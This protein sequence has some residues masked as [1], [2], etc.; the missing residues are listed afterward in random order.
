MPINIRQALCFDD[1]QLI[2]GFNPVRSRSEVSL[3]NDEGYIPIFIA[4]MMAVNSPA[5]QRAAIEA[6]IVH[7][8]HRYNT[9]Q[10]RLDF[11][12][13]LELKGEGRKN[14]G[15]SIGMQDD[16]YDDI[17]RLSEA[18]G[19][20][21]FDVAACYSEAVVTHLQKILTYLVGTDTHLIVGNYSNPAFAELIASL[22]PK[23]LRLTLKVSQGG[24]GVCSTRLMTG[25]GVP[26]F[27]AVVDSA[28]ITQANG[29]GLIADGG[30]KTPGDM[31]KAFAAGATGV[32][33]GGMFAAHTECDSAYRIVTEQGVFYEYFG[34][35]SERAKK[36]HFQTVKNVEGV[37]SL[38]RHKGHV[39]GTI[40]TIKDGLQSGV[41]M[42]GFSSLRDLIGEGQFVQV[43]G[44]GV[45]EAST[46]SK[47]GPSFG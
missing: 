11:V 1:V 22:A 8:L 3:E 38:K 4:P 28:P 29:Y 14:I 15:L 34:M 13:G 16:K 44:A 6:N 33:C 32:M 5:M 42:Q 39:K 43:S 24:S 46:Y 2:D 12:S 35:A 20:L 25:V 47:I 7:V 21:N 41:S 36:Q 19:H 26:T 40:G 18:A 45:R 10:D 30:V 23:D 37:S 17:M 27:Q 31:V 9:V